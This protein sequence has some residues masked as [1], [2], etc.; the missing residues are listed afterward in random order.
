MAA[1]AVHGG[2]APRTLGPVGAGFGRQ[3]KVGE[4]RG[5][6]E[7]AQG[8]VLH[9]GKEALSYTLIPTLILTHFPIYT[10]T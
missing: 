7:R 2:R 3:R 9:A 6:W 8:T 5:P 10:H 1:W 4:A